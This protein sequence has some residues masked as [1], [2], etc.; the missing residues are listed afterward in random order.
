MGLETGMCTQW[1]SWNSLG[2]LRHHPR[3]G[4]FVGYLFYVLFGT[5]MGLLSVILVVTFASYA[6]GSGIAEIKIILGGFGMK[7]YLGL[8]TLLIKSA[9]LVL[10]V[11]SGLCLG[12]EGPM[13]H[14]ACACGN[15]LS[16]LFPSYATNEAKKREILSASAAAGISVAFG[17]PIGG[18]LF[19]LEVMGRR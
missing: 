17:A 2:L 4:F 14:I 19:S 9:S 5:V 13:V 16:K 1:T 18:V 11:A 12:R 6:S 15:I 10:S 7:G 3:I 8:R